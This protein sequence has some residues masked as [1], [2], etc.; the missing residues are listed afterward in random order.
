M[1]KTT[2]RK[3]SAAKTITSFLCLSILCCY[4]VLSFR[5][6]VFVVCCRSGSISSTN[7]FFF[8]FYL[9]F[10]CSLVSIR[11][12]HFLPSL[13][14]SISSLQHWEHWMSHGQSPWWNQED[15]GLEERNRSCSM[16]IA[17]FYWAPLSQSRFVGNENDVTCRWY[18]YIW[19]SIIDFLSLLFSFCILFPIFCYVF[20]IWWK[21]ALY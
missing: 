8:F 7:N 3:F 4:H 17:F 15:G 6:R 11:L 18:G 20:L 1:I 9:F 12:F 14:N 5:E 13:T 2:P 21:G 10:S 19:F 16:S